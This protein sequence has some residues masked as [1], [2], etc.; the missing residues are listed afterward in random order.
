MV[1]CTKQNINLSVNGKNLP[2][3]FERYTDSTTI[4]DIQ[5]EDYFSDSHLVALIDTAL[6]NNP[7]LQIAFQRVELAKAGL[8]QA[9]G[10]LSPTVSANIAPAI[11][12]YGLYTMDGAGNISTEMTPGKMVP[13]DLPDYYVGL[14]ASWEIDIWKKLNNRKKS[15]VNQVL[16]SV[17]GTNLVTTNLITEIAIAY[18]ELIALDNEQ[19]ILSETIRNQEEVLDVIRYQK[20][21]GRANELVVQQFRAQQLNTKT[22]ERQVLQSIIETE[23]K[24]NYLLGRYPQPISRNKDLLFKDLPA[25]VN[26]GIPAQMLLNRPD[27]RAAKYALE[28]TKFDLKAA[29]AEFL[30]SLNLTAGVGFQAFNPE[31]LFKTPASIAYSLVGGLTAPIINKKAIQARFNTAKANQLIAM[32]DYQKSILNGYTEV[33]NE[34]TRIN[35]LREISDLKSLQSQ[36]LEE[37]VE[38]SRELYSSAKATYLEV[39]IAQQNTIQAKLE[40]VESHKKQLMAS[41]NIYKA[42]GGGWK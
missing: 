31:Y 21:A 12:R 25:E 34:L 2:K 39:L 19:D 17:E 26:S 13:K 10:A 18:Y 7:D 14:Q 42:L 11:R 20:E 16:S 4:A 41:V 36:V 9:R 23:N 30:P 29:N 32:H 28:S 6:A 22:L 37:S 15:A 27:I 38:T 1:G 3:Q 8:L 33:V 5:W 24:I 40:N 35:A